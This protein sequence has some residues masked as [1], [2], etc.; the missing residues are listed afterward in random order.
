M[1]RGFY[2]KKFP[3]KFGELF[4][5]FSFFRIINYNICEKIV[6]ITKNQ[7]KRIIKEMAMKMPADLGKTMMFD[8]EL[9]TSEND[10]AFFNSIQ[11]KMYLGC[12]GCKLAGWLH[13]SQRIFKENHN[14]ECQPFEVENVRVSEY[15]KEAEKTGPLLYDI[16]MEIAGKDGLV[17]DR[18]GSTVDASKV[19]L[20][21]LYKR[22]DIAHKEITDCQLNIP[23]YVIGT[24]IPAKYASKIF[25]KNTDAPS[26]IDQLRKMG[27]LRFKGQFLK[28]EI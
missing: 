18:G 16:A 3:R 4:D 25:I 28:R 6:R 13:A 8:V 27:V 14:N 15:V 17:S 2:C 20:H 24:K 23:K 5:M 19:W 22:N 10:E 1:A 9:S 12:F 21:Y 26:M 7:L 11:I